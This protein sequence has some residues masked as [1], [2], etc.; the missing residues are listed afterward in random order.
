MKNEAEF[1]I[2]FKKWI[3]A[4]PPSVSTAYELKIE[5]TNTFNIYQWTQKQGHQLRSLLRVQDSCIFHKISD[6]SLGQKPF[7]CFALV[8]TAAFLV[9]HYKK[10]KKSI[11]INPRIILD[12]LNKQK[13]GITYEEFLL[14]G[15]KEI[16]IK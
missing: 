4:T 5:R 7:D 12:L 2:K 14:L 13:K 8:R 15:A 3:E 6:M 9:I 16:N 11:K 1:Q 10:E